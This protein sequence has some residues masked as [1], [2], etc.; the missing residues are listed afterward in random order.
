MR[1]QRFIF[2]VW[3]NSCIYFDELV[4]YW[5]GVGVQ[6]TK[7]DVQYRDLLHDRFTGKFREIYQ[8][9]NN[10]HSNRVSLFYN[11]LRPKTPQNSVAIELFLQTTCNNNDK[12]CSKQIKK[13]SYY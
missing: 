4:R 7:V 5:V 8:V 6:E 1:V 9:H 13:T 3:T 12:C 10:T 2:F 11:P